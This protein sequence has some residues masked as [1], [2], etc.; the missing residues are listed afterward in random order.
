M[1]WFS[2]NFPTLSR[3]FSSGTRNKEWARRAAGDRPPI[4]A[5]PAQ[6]QETDPVAGPAEHTNPVALSEDTRPGFAP[7]AEQSM[8]GLSAIGETKSAEGRAPRYGG[9]VP[10]PSLDN[11][12]GP[13]LDESYETWVGLEER[14]IRAQEQL[15]LVLANRKRA[16]LL[17]DEARLVF[18]QADAAWAEAQRLGDA[19]WRAFNQSFAE[20][21]R[22]P[23]SRWRFVK[24]IY[25]A[26]MVQARLQR[27][28]NKDAW[29]EA[30]RVRE[31]A[32][33]ELLKAL[34]AIGA[35]AA[36]VE[37]ELRE[38]ASLPPASEALRVIALED[39]RYAQGL[40]GDRAHLGPEAV[41]QLDAA[42]ITEQAPR[43]QSQ[44]PPLV[45][46]QAPARTDR[47][48]PVSKHPESVR[49]QVDG[50]TSGRGEP[51]PEPAM[52]HSADA[53]KREEPSPPTVQSQS[54]ET[55][56]RASGP[57]TRSPAPADSQESGATSA[58]EA[59]REEMEAAAAR[60]RQQQNR[61]PSAE[62]LTNSVE[63][64][65][66]G[67]DTAAEELERGLT[68]LRDL[69][70][71]PRPPQGGIP[72]PPGPRA[73][74][75]RIVDAETVTR[76][77]ANPQP[78][79]ARPAGPGGSEE[80]QVQ[81]SQFTGAAPSTDGPGAGTSRTLPAVYTGRLYLM[82]PST[83]NQDGLEAVWEVLEEVAGMGA[84]VDTQLISREAGIQFTLDLGN[85]QL[86]LEELRKRLPSS[87][88]T[89]LGA[90]RLK[91]DWRP[92]R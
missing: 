51:A 52:P 37:R 88:M 42:R 91:V 33:G 8:A 86:V 19:A 92:R 29:S 5:A 12:A 66:A 74:A 15:Q 4:A 17:R 2:R 85:R 36:Q 80:R 58:A 56:A 67:D 21:L 3:L 61:G 71:A 47:E 40:G 30:D 78:P 24:E 49:R 83:I 72:A 63:A 18:G 26:R 45:P 6:S 79:G 62:T 9:P 48:A 68:S 22:G 14:L 10:Q 35:A 60:M 57:G 81:D 25:E 43:G 27:A 70:A 89:E 82:F 13:Q 64:P 46:Q 31:A 75:P 28:S 90:D 32:T 7:G 87:G 65:A 77:P 44:A 84:I 55:A 50:A 76:P 59:L 1:D 34:S 39:L 38:V 16:A 41:D 11:A 20:G 73:G 69:F 54:R 23:A 53:S